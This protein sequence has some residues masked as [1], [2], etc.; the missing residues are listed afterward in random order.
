MEEAER[1][2]YIILLISYNGS[3]NAVFVKP[4]S[5]A[6]ESSRYSLLW[7]SLTY[8]LQSCKACLGNYHI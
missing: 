6:L 8:S 3:V 5:V 7:Q 2:E 1:G 4:V